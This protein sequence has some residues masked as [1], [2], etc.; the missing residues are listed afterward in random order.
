M[1]TDRNKA[2]VRRFFEE[3]WNQRNLT[4]VND[5]F[6]PHVIVNG[7]D[8]TPEV[9]KQL[10]ESRLSAFPD[11][12]VTIDEQVAEADKVSTRRT[13]RGTHLGE[14][15]GIAPTGKTASWEQISIVRLVDEKIVED[16]VVADELSLLTQ[17]GQAW[18]AL[19]CRD[20]ESGR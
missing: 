5:I 12:V 17:L 19:R 9:I 10:I 16:R 15:R 2:I 18:Q 3:V 11:I 1:P 13:W 20:I 4:A 7:Q 14:F 8:V 6:A